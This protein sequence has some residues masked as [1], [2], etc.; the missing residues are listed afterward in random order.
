MLFGNLILPLFQVIRYFDFD[1]SQTASSLTMFIE[2]YSNIYIHFIKLTIKYI[3]I[4]NLSWVENIIIFSI[5][6]VK[7]KAV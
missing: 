3:F 6:L 1:Q 4:I 2:K 5:N 7:P